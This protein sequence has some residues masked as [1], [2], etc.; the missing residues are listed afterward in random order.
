M[1]DAPGAGAP[2][3]PEVAAL[4]VMVVDDQHLVRRGLALLLDTVDGVEV[5]AEAGGG[6]E[7][8]ALLARDLPD[9]VLTDA[10]MPGMSGA[11]LV[12]HC[13]RAHPGLPVIVLTTFDDDDL[14]L[15]ALDA[16]A[17]GFLL[18]DTSPE[19]LADAIAAAS[20]GEMVLDPRVTRLAL[21]R[22]ASATGERAD[23]RLAVLTRTEL[24]VARHVSRGLSNAA[25][26]AELVLAEGTVKNHVSALLRKLDQPDRTNLALTLREVFRTSQ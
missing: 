8:V 14:V 18:K 12:A 25:I 10:R 23:D 26:A 11:E 4:R 3:P 24:V 1:T 5:V 16:G 22:T 21:H 17:S 9:V 7:A 6:A 15:G 13:A 19:R 2:G 20:R